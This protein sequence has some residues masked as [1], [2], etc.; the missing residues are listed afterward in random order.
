MGGSNHTQT[1]PIEIEQWPFIQPRFIYTIAAAE[2]QISSEDGLRLNFPAETVHRTFS[3]QNTAE[4]ISFTDSEACEAWNIEGEIDRSG[5]YMGNSYRDVRLR[6][7]H[8]LGV[9]PEKAAFV[10][11]ISLVAGV[12]YCTC[13]PDSPDCF[14]AA[15]HHPR[16]I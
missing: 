11:L 13:K 8:H 5:F 14:C 10:H 16:D 2:A 9:A 1:V 7:L 15:V 3:W 12:Y 6:R 4:E